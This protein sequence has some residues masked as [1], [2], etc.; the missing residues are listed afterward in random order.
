M[1]RKT[2]TKNVSQS[3]VPRA[4]LKAHGIDRRAFDQMIAVGWQFSLHTDGVWQ[5]SITQP[6]GEIY[7]IEN[8]KITALLDDA[9]RTWERGEFPE[10]TKSADPEEVFSEDKIF[11]IH[12]SNIVPS[13]FE[14]Q[15]R[16]RAKFKPEE[17]EALGDSI[18]NQGLFSPIVV[19]PSRRFVRTNAS[20]IYEIVFGERRFLAARLKNLSTIKCFVRELTD[21]QV[22]E[23]QYQENHQRGDNDPLDDAFLFQFLQRRENYS[24]GALADKFGTSE[25]DVRDKLK[26]N[27]LISDAVQELADGRLPLRHAY[28]LA[29]FP[30][31][32][33]TE[34]VKAQYAYRWHDRDEKAVS[35]N[36]FKAE[37]EENVL[38]RLLAAPFDVNDS[39][40]HIRGLLCRDC[41]DNSA[42]ATH[43]FPE[44]ADAARCLNKACFD[45]KTNTNLRL[46]RD[47]IAAQKPNPTHA[48][49]EEIAATVPLVTERKW[50]DE[51]TPFKEKILT[52]QKLADAPECEFSELSLAVDGARKGQR[53]WICRNESCARH[54]PKPPA[55][56]SEKLEQ[57]EENF[58]REVAE[59][60]RLR[61]LVA[62]TGWFDQGNRAFWEFDDLVRR[63][64]ETALF[65]FGQA[66]CYDLRRIIKARWKSKAKPNLDDP[67]EIAVFVRALDAR[68]RSQ[69]LLLLALSGATDEIEIAKIARDFGA[70]D[71]LRADAEAR[72]ELAPDEFKSRA[73][74]YLQK[75]KDGEA[76]DV[77]RFWT[78]YDDVPE[79]SGE[80][81]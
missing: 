7:I 64:I 69:I 36:E 71:Y 58:N 81:N 39:R 76:A 67:E 23:F 13:P 38:R 33:Q 2:Q 41:P 15:A 61:T 43:L 34:I 68:E 70:P 44:L 78:H 22:L 80:E 18:V 37:V 12:L 45:L 21:S 4:A 40:L 8:E 55:P 25:R 9:R 11:K 54:H 35:C 59:E 10:K 1:Q 26:L 46:Q 75:V 30:P 53:V 51:R 14:P 56:V 57:L 63:L 24:I 16:R 42:Q 66:N 74:E 20:V 48:P 19:R 73:A 32:T 50:S 62:A 60:A 47:A 31:Q 28:Y 29:K 52:D 6:D 17:L 49:V 72:L 27:D 3:T 77:P 65:E 79:I 5:A